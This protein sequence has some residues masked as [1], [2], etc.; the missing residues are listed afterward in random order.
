M[1]EIC[2]GVEVY[3]GLA[4][5]ANET[6]GAGSVVKPRFN[7]NFFCHF[8]PNALFD[9]TFFPFNHQYINNIDTLELVAVYKNTENSAAL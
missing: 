8:S 9:G 3:R 4:S 6:E 5:G 2:Y 1:S 7:S